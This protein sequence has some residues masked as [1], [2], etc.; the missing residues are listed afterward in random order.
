[1][2]LFYLRLKPLKPTIT[3]A[4]LGRYLEPHPSSFQSSLTAYQFMSHPLRFWVLAFWVSMAAPLLA[5][6][7]YWIHFAD[8]PGHDQ[9]SPD[10]LLSPR[11]WQRRMAQ[12]IPL[13][14][15]DYPVAEQYL[16]QVAALGVA[17]R[18]PSRWLNAVSAPLT[19]DQ[20]AAVRELPFV[21]DLR[22]L[23]RLAV[24][25]DLAETCPDSAERNSHLRQLEMLDL[26]VLH[27]NQLTGQGVL[28]AVFDNGFYGVDQ[29]P[30]FDHLFAEGR[31]IGTRD[32]VDGD[33]D[34]YHRCSHCRHG[35]YVFSLLAAV[36]P[37]ELIGSAPGADYLLL[38]TENDASETPQEE[39]NWVAAAEYADSM[40]AAIFTTSLGYKDFDGF[41]HDYAISDLDGNTA[42]I[43]RAADVAASRGIVVLNSAGNNGVNG[44]NAPAD[45]DSVLA[46]GSVDGCE[47]YSSF[48]SQGPRVDGHLKP[49]LSAMGQGNYF[50]HPDGSVRRGNGTSFSCP[51]IAGLAACL[52]QGYPGLD[53]MALYRAL[54]ESAHQYST[55]DFFLGYGIPRGRR[56]W[57]MLQARYP[58][59]AVLPDLQT[60]IAPS[61]PFRHS[62]LAVYPNP[63]SGQVYLSLRSPIAVSQLRLEW[64]D[65]MGRRLGDQE[66]SVADL[67]NPHRFDAPH[68]PGIYLLRVQNA[69]NHDLLFVRKVIIQA[70]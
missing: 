20:C 19:P 55:P 36:M 41:E 53:N 7:S 4:A 22:P 70:P 35:T 52:L 24:P 17:Y 65:L 2:I 3:F 11:A 64:T 16:A 23:G 43:T 8:K 10:Q 1:M 62:N 46:I 34:V 51:M 38:R 61:D 56:T 21:T 59:L 58:Q 33:D 6:P 27:R 69:E 39:D 25:T 40:G 15:Y 63:S 13:D 50:L 9:V 42:T 67:G 66:V 18:Y 54:R 45:G 14:H 30:G 57:K 60:D 49:D 31:I 32:Y 26:E 12:G 5:Q 47:Q 29:L 28:V 68:Q 48:S 37:G 44:L